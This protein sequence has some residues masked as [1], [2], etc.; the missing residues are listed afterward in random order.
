[1]F[2]GFIVGM[3]LVV[4][5][6]S[7]VNAAGRADECAACLEKRFPEPYNVEVEHD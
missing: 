3:I 4:M 5:V 7:F 1:M 2:L 6:M